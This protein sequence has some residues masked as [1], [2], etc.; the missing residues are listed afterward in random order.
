MLGHP[1][2]SILRYQQLSQG[3]FPKKKY[4]KLWPDHGLEM[5]LATTPFL[6]LSSP[7]LPIYS[8]LLLRQMSGPRPAQLSSISP[9]LGAWAG[10][11][12]EVGARPAA[13]AGGQKSPWPQH[14]GYFH[15]WALSAHPSS[16]SSLGM[17]SCV[18]PRGKLR[19]REGKLLTPKSC[20]WNWSPSLPPPT[21]GSQSLSCLNFNY[22]DLQPVGQEG[23]RKVNCR[24]QRWAFRGGA[25]LV[26]QGLLRPPRRV[27]EGC[28]GP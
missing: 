18:L 17:L 4:G 1:H 23:L 16:P 22:T 12:P 7:F 8:P 5:P 19:P 11:S 6:I 2:L 13:S 21:S 9:G 26:G 20:N 28:S 3:L 14:A 10:R 25:S 15:I 27:E 24:L